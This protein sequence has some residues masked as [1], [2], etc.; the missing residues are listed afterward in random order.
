VESALGSL[1]PDVAEA[2]RESIDGAVA[3]AERLPADAGAEL[4]ATARDA[5]TSGVHAVGAVSAVAF[6]GLAVLAAVALR[7]ARGVQG[8]EPE[9]SPEPDPADELDEAEPCSEMAPWGPYCSTY[10]R[11]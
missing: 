3:A 7:H 11:R 4:L 8:E 9:Q 5:F 6:T 2:A 10:R 1:P